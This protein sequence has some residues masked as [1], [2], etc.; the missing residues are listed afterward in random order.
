[1]LNLINFLYNM[2]T[3]RLCYIKV[4]SRSFEEM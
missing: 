1:M 2:L 4:E 3:R